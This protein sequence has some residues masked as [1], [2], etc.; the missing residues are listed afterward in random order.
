LRAKRRGY[1][2]ALE[3]LEKLRDS[4]SDKNNKVVW[5]LAMFA[6]RKL[7]EAVVSKA[8]EHN[9]SVVFVDPR[10]TSSTCPRCGSKIGYIGRLGVC[11][12][13]G[14]R[15]ERDVIGAMNIWIRA[16]EAYAGVPGSPPRAPAM[17]SEARG[18]G[19][20]KDEGMRKVMR[21]Y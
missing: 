7:Q 9:V 4:F 16:V 13:C 6:Y 2:I 3:D 8:V 11:P 19:G 12:R 14:F 5:K 20:T 21:N 10:N 17:N 1:A 18:S 15:A